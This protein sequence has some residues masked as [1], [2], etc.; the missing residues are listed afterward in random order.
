MRCYRRLARPANDLAVY[1]RL[2]QMLS[3][4]LG[5]KP[6]PVS[7]VLAL[8]LR[9]DLRISI[10]HC[11]LFGIPKVE[12]IGYTARHKLRLIEEHYAEYR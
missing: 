6:S 4:K 12:L 8:K 5:V 3:I 7:R 11:T 1:Q 10:P 9:T 2:R